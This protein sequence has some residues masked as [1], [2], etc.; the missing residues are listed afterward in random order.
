VTLKRRNVLL[1]S[2]KLR[3]I[4]FLFAL[5]IALPAAAEKKKLTLEDLTA[6]PPLAGRPVSGLT[7]LPGQD[8]FSFI[9]RQGPGEDAKSELIVEDAKT[10]KRVAAATAETL[11]LPEE[12]R[13]GEVAPGVSKQP[14]GAAEGERPGRRPRRVSLDGYRWSPDGKTI[15]LSGDNDLWL[16]DVAQKRLR[17]LTHDPE[18]EEFPSF[19]PDGKR[20]AFVRNNDLYT[21]ELSSGSENRLTG[22]GGEHVFDGKLDWAYEEE[23]ANRTGRAYEWSPDS[24]SIAYVRLDESP[25]ESYP[26]VDFLKVPAAVTFQ[27]YP[28]AGTPNSNV[29]FLVVGV[30]GRSRAEVRLGSD[31][32]VEPA[33]SWTPDSRFVCY[34]DLNRA[35][36]RQEVQLLT[37][38]GRA[39]RTL[40]V[41]H[42]PYWL[43]VVEPPRFLKDGRYLWKSER[44]GFA[45]LYVGS[46]SGGEPRAITSGNWMVDRIAGVDEERKL[47][48]FTA[49]EE[50]VRRRALYRVSLDGSGF[51]RL[52]LAP[53]THSAELSPD[54]RYLLDTFSTVSKPPVVSLLE[55][56]GKTIRL[57]HQPENRLAEYELATTEEVEVAADDGTKLEARLV[58]PAGFDPSKKYPVIVY[59]YGGP[60]AQV[61][62]DAWGTTSLFDHYMASKGFLIWSLDNRGSWGRGHQWESAIFKETGKRELSDQ[63]AG[64][65]YLKS[66]PYVD[67][68]RIGIWGWS[69]GGYMT[70]YAL[71]NAPDAW[72]CGIAGAPV[73]HWKFYDTIYTERYMRTPAENP[74]GYEASAPL[75]KAKDLK[76]KLLLIHGTADDNVHMQNTMAFVDA[77]TK[78]GRPYQLEIQPGQKHGFRGRESLNFRN[79]AM[80]RFFEENL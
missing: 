11:T 49:T 16:Y 9:E 53:G 21:I 33:F 80:A 69:Y 54:G 34:R 38:P 52:P 44:S 39:P 37:L 43:N 47:V 31:G 45:H 72:K 41:E 8:R 10:G 3:G 22:D 30:D 64:V 60:H 77:L 57:V 62:H 28:K 18:R 13:P 27:R 78:A 23:L 19:S 63:L 76:A 40:F 36:D 25:V 24:S 5:A 51:E 20:V 46:V 68:S 7:W 55:T 66:L 79:A 74:K 67:P 35:Q 17:R 4:V 61:V 15:L 42:D 1:S 58:K 26:L 50:N 2:W 6:E 48:Y 14:P 59:V 75:S 70:L 71:T 12:P 29:S 73:T 56:S 32:Y 65:K